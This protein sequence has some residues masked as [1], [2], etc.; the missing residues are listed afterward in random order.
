MPPA[1]VG[2][3]PVNSTST[4][5]AGSPVRGSSFQKLTPLRYFQE[6]HSPR[7]HE[8]SQGRLRVISTPDGVAKGWNHG[9]APVFG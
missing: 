7:C 9:F 5:A 6:N 3:A 1:G 8:W 4:R 2:A